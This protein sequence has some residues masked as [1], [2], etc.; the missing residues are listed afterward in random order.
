MPAHD[1][2]YGIARQ[3]LDTASAGLTAAGLTA[4]ERQYVADGN[5]VAWDCE[6]L[7]VAIVATYSHEG[8]VAQE[9][10]MPAFAMAPRAAEVEVWLARCAPTMDEDGTPAAAEAIDASAGVVLADP[11]VILDCLWR[12]HAA[13][14]LASCKGLVFR[15]W[16]AV[17]PSGGLTGGVLR[18]AVNL[19]D[20]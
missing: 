8:N 4:P 11:M 2:L 16:Q 12:A 10:Q 15:R 18:L 17:G 20:V 14:N 9:T 1:R 13:G 5:M 6:Q 3:I 19:T 7:V